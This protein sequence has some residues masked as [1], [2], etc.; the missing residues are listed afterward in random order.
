MKL[1]ITKQRKF[2]WFVS[3]FLVVTS[4]VAMA[5]S[6]ANFQA[7]LR[8]GLDFVG[9]TRIQLERA[10]T[11]GA[12]TQG[13]S[14]QGANCSQPLVAG[15][16][17]QILEQQDLEDSSIQ[18]LGEEQQALSIRTANLLPEQRSQLQTELD[19][20]FGPFD[21]ERSQIDSVGPVIGRRLLISG[22][23][24]LIVAFSGIVIYLSIR[25]R[26]D[27][28]FLAIVALFHDVLITAGFFSVLGLAQGLEVNTLFLVALLTIAGFS[29]NDTVVI[30]DRIR[31]TT[32]YN[33]DRSISIIIDDAVNQTLG[34][35]INTTLTTVMP[36]LAI[37]LL[38]GATLKSF[39]LALI[40][41]F[42]LGAY[43]SIFVASS[44]LGWWRERQEAL[45]PVMAQAAESGEGV[46]EA[47]GE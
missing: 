36:L 7:P 2:W 34:R 21:P 39:V 35:S 37:L 46:A 27:Y 12:S 16:V 26:F 28:A 44:L 13:A 9:G 5:I 41:G 4:L 29:V 25:F 23:L 14:T 20:A 18:I 11:Q 19:Q 10:C 6:W 43:S 30:Y 1:Q 3:G 31:E 22:L 47:E 15:E 42:L 33:P 45:N 8:L 40:I 24:A 32:K 38:G 17:R